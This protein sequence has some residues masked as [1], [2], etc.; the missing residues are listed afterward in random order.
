MR[1]A[2]QTYKDTLD[3]EGPAG[4]AFLNARVPHR[5]TAIYRLDGGRLRNVFL[6][7]KQGEVRPDFLEVVPLADSFCQFVI[8]DGLFKTS[9]TAQDHRLDGHKYQGVLMTYHG[10]PLLD[11]G[12]QLFGTLCHFDAESLQL[13]DAE[14]EFFSQAARLLPPYLARSQ[15]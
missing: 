12:A 7:D 8:R 11:N 14:F 5:Y 6:F 1:N 2:L 13:S 9:N 3:R 10:V 4:L 15:A